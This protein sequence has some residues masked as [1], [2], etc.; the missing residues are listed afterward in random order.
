[1]YDMDKR[2]FWEF[3]RFSIGLLIFA[4]A[5]SC[6]IAPILIP[7]LILE[8]FIIEKISKKIRTMKQEVLEKKQMELNFIQQGYRKICDK[9]FVNQNTNKVNIE[10]KDY[11][12]SQIIDCN[13]VA[14][15]QPMNN[16]YGRVNTNSKLYPNLN[17]FSVGMDYCTQL[18]INITIND[19]NNP[20]I[21]LDFKGDGVVSVSSGRYKDAIEGANNALSI[22]KVI[23]NQNNIQKK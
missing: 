13:L 17:T 19:L 12:F 7:I 16:T 2:W 18:Y 21:K 15:N 10:G 14:I 6:I 20:N 3:W 9:L 1:M 11:D 8:I 23:I 22:L 4:T 5:L